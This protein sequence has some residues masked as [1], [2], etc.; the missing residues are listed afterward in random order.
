MDKIAAFQSEQSRSWVNVD[1][2]V[3]RMIMGYD[4]NL[5]MVKVRFKK[6]ATG[7][8][9][10]HSHIQSTYIASGSFEVI[11]DGDTSVL[12]AGDTF[13][14]APNLVHGVVCKEDGVLV[15]VFHP[16]REDFL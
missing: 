11:I 16:F 14:V 5:M 8:L 1:P 12:T 2:G 15:D 4:H 3:D 7:A 6:G 10:S 9:H 13:F